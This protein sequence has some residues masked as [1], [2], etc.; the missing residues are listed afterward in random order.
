M[1]TD[2]DYTDPPAYR[3]NVRLRGEWNGA[4]NGQSDR[5]SVH[6]RRVYLQPKIVE[7]VAQHA[8]ET[9]AR[10]QIHRPRRRPST[11]SARAVTA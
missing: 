7:V 9:G 10:I 2:S 8:R 5:R 6:P 3:D 11:R 1:F 4:N